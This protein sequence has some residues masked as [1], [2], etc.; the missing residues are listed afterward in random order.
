MKR[1]ISSPCVLPL[2]G[3]VESPE[4]RTAFK[5][6]AIGSPLKCFQ[7]RSHA[8]KRAQA[9]KEPNR[10]ALSLSG[11]NEH[12]LEVRPNALRNLSLGEKSSGLGISFL[13][14]ATDQSLLQYP[15]YDNAD[16]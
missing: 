16:G 9:A 10:S 4:E 11:V 5:V 13:D 8:S 12:T 15:I 1:L 7:V 2:L 3:C 14:W 6:E